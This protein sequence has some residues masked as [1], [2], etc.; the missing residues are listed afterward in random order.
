M[1]RRPAAIKRPRSSLAGRVRLDDQGVDAV[2]GDQVA[3][4]GVD[5]ALAVDPRLAGEG[6]GLDPDGEVALARARM[7]GVPEV[8]VA[9]VDHLERRRRQRRASAAVRF[10]RARAHVALPVVVA[11]P[12]IGQFPARITPA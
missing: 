10:L 6:G 9:V 7:A 11:G 2:G 4:R 5:R 3:E 12:Y 1:R 8:G